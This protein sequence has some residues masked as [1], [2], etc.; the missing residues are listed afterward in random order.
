MSQALILLV[1]T[2]LT[3]CTPSESATSTP[4]LTCSAVEAVCADRAV[5]DTAA[6]PDGLNVADMGGGLVHV[7]HTNFMASCCL[8]FEATATLGA[9]RIDVA[10]A[11]V[12]E[13]CDCV[14]PY[15]MGYDITGVPAGSYTVWAGGASAA[16]IVE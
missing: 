4:E 5:A 6:G 13:P 10:Y 8:D 11:E 3:A 14:C 12:G 16:L 9:E 15:S 1:L 2:V 7:I